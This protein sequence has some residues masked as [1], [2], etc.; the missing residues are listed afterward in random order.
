MKF[1]QTG[2]NQQGS[3]GRCLWVDGQG[4]PPSGLM[5]RKYVMERW[6]RDRTRMVQKGRKLLR[7][8]QMLESCLSPGAMVKE[9]R[10]RRRE[11]VCL[12]PRAMVM[13]RPGYC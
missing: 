1:P 4:P 9:V 7:R 6:E 11:M 8:E 10:R 13:S 2:F 5:I 12:P 3:L